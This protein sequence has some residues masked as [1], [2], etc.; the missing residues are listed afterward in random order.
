MD[1]ICEYCSYGHIS[2]RVCR[3]LRRINLVGGD[4]TNPSLQLNDQ[5]STLKGCLL[6]TMGFFPYDK[7]KKPIVINRHHLHA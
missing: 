6:I 4:I 2:A 3:D 1:M 5:F 7:L